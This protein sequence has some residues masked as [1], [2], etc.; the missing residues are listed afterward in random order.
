[1]P[2][3]VTRAPPSLRGVPP[4]PSC[5]LSPLLLRP[6]SLVL[7]RSVRR[8]PPA[9][10]VALARAK[11]AG[12]VVEAAGAVEAAVEAAEEVRVVAGVVAGVEVSAAA[13]E[14][15]AVV[16]AATVGVAVAAEVVAAAAEEAAEVVA[17]RGGVAPV[18][19]SAS[20]SSVVR[21]PSPR[22]SSVSGT[23]HV[24]GVGVL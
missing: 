19:V 18:V 20:S 2:L 11:G 1:G 10:D 4:P 9:G 16:A 22:S 6:T 21:R 7:S 17:R 24:R 14:A 8:L 3:V 5:P 13:V 15:E 23:L 12:A